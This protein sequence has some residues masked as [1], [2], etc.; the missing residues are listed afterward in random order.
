[1]HD[2]SYFDRSIPPVIGAQQRKLFG[3]NIIERSTKQIQLMKT[4][5]LDIEQV[6]FEN[7]THNNFNGIGVNKLG[8]EFVKYTYQQSKT[9]E[10]KL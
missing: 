9:S 3:T 7:R 10:K 2:M 8:D 6:I 1:M 5:G 4:M